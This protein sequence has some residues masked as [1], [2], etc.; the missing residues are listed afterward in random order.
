[1]AFLSDS[2]LLGLCFFR[3]FLAPDPGLKVDG[4]EGG[5]GSTVLI[6]RLCCGALGMPSL[7]LRRDMPDGVFAGALN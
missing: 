2:S 6:L 1:M 5:T 7:S 3:L 4:N